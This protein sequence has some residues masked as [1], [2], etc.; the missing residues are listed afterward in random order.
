MYRFDIPERRRD[1]R[2]YA[3]FPL[4]CEL[5]NSKDNSLKEIVCPVY[6][7]NTKGIFFEIERLNDALQLE[8]EVRAR[9][10]LPG[11]DSISRVTLKVVRVE[12][13]DSGKI[14]VGAVFT[15][16]S[17]DDRAEIKKIVEC[18]DINIFFEQAVKKEASDM[19]FLV[20]SPPVLRIAGGLEQLG[21]PAL[22]AEDI[23][24]MVY[25]VM[26]RQQIR[27]FE[28]DKE[29]DFGVQYNAEN[30]FRANVHQ[31]RGFLEATFRLVNSHIPTLDELGLPPVAKE[32]ARSKE[33]LVL[34]VGPTGSGKTTTI[35]AMVEQI[36]L[37]KRVVVITLERP[38]EYVHVNNKSIIKQR[39]VGVDTSSF[40]VALKSSLR[41]DP[42][43]IVVGEIDDVETIRTA[44]TASEA[45]YLVIASFHA[46]NTIQA[47]DRLANFFPPEYHKQI[48]FQLSNCLRGFIA[49]LLIPRVDKK[50]RVLAAEVAIN[51][52]AVK[53]IIRNNELT[54]LGTAIQTGQAYKMQSM[55]ACI[56]R[57]YEQGVIDGETAQIYSQE[58]NTYFG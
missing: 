3:R 40:S 28:Q 16:I 57:Y 31:Q 49:Q 11:G 58:Y 4:T 5:V 15:Q 45:G 30:R 53:R 2:I 44:I 25:S 33:G 26:S 9:F 56:K 29:L 8:E 36:N 14:S 24:S 6:N 52:D 46:P 23:Q 47:I 27:R 18:R 38:I 41:Q 22:S 50:G 37:E 13:T 51:N 10:Q 20:N 1:A 54:Q 32:L 42:N 48:L 7:I 55:T 12:I 35:A 39:E 19:H 34:I 21:V 43:V 17:E